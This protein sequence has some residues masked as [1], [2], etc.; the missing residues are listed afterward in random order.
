MFVAGLKMTGRDEGIPFKAPAH[1]SPACGPPASCSSMTSHP[2]NTTCIHHSSTGQVDIPHTI[3]N[4][5]S[6][7]NSQQW[8]LPRSINPSQMVY[9][10]HPR[11]RSS[12]HSP[13]LPTHIPSSTYSSQ[14][15][16]LP[17]SSSSQRQRRKTAPR[18]HLSDPSSTRCP[19]ATTLPSH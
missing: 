7:T 17:F 4:H 12:S 18:L 6:R 2:T 9:T 14:S 5:D 11:S 15:T 1:A 8:P 13:Y 10:L 16:Q 19:T 3:S